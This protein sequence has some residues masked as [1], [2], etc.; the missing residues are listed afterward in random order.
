MW[1]SNDQRKEKIGD[2]MRNYTVRKWY[3]E[4]IGQAITLH[5]AKS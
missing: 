5:L 2:N 3:K 1:Q 4:A